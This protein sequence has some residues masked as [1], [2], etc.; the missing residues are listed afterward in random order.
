MPCPLGLDGGGEI[1]DADRQDTEAAQ[2]LDKAFVGSRECRP[3]GMLNS[4][5]GIGKVDGGRR[6]EDG[7]AEEDDGDALDGEQ[8][9]GE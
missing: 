3:H 8:D 6:G 1:H 5:G 7:V 2:S 4:D 9:G